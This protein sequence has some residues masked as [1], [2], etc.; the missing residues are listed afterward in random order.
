MI[1][2]IGRWLFKDGAEDNPSDAASTPSRPHH[3]NTTL[4]YLEARQEWDERFAHHVADANAWRRGCVYS[5]LAIVVLVIACVYL[6]TRLTIIPVVVEVN[7][8]RGEIVDSYDPTQLNQVIS[9]NVYRWLITQWLENLRSVTVDPKVQGENIADLA[10]YVR[11]VDPT[12]TMVQ[13]IINKVDPYTTAQ[14]KVITVKVQELRK[15]GDKHW[16]VVWR[17]R[18]TPRNGTPSSTYEYTGTL[19]VTQGAVAA[20]AVQRNPLGIYITQFD[21]SEQG[22][23]VVD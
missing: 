23:P 6:A 1:K 22:T 13:E 18:N 15:L 17:E 7:A 3:D 4:A 21:W 14:T 12:Y 5:I 11:S 20:D 8:E 9:D 19:H 16:Y 10:A 2:T